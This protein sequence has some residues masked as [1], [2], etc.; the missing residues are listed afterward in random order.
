MND[1]LAQKHGHLVASLRALDTC[2][3]AF[4]GGVDSA[5][6]ARVAYEV[7]Q[8]NMRAVTLSIQGMTAD[9]GSQAQAWC[10]EVGIPHDTI[11]FNELSI[12]GFVQ[13]PPDRCYLCKR[14]LFRTLL[15]F[16]NAHGFAHVVEGSNVDDMGDYR[17][18]IK[19]LGELGIC[20][21]LRDAGLSKADIRALA[22]ELGIPVWNRPSSAC[23]SSRIPYGELI[24]PA[25]LRRI[26]A[27]E[28]YLHEQGLSQVRVRA[29]GDEGDL[30]RIEVMAEDIARFLEPSLRTKV[31]AHLK[32]LGFRY[33]CLDL[34]GFRSGSMN[35]VLK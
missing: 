20:S 6:L 32:T 14:E 2:V 33:V 34:S 19:A 24:T 30:A 31:D 26:E 18:G 12:P 10:H 35:E 4:S 23:L 17:P 8:D 3:V 9:E 13:N 1:K 7:L 27:G 21:P 11:A 25:K 15:S 16:A 22:R 28:R 5:L 29:Y